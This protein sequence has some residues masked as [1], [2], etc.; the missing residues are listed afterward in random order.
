V[1]LEVEWDRAKAVSNLRKPEVSFEE[2][3]TVLAD[4]L[5][6]ILDDPDHSESEPRFLLLGRAATGRSLIVAIT[7]RGERV[8]LISARTMTPRERKAYERE[9]ERL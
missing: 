4:P 5:S 9:I 1:S 2:A 3:A 6:I 8:R 7:E